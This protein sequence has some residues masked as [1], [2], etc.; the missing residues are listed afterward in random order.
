MTRDWRDYLADVLRYSEIATDLAV[1]SDEANP[2]DVITVL[3]LERA[4][5]IVGEAAGKVP[6][7]VRT[8]YLDLSWQ[9]MIGA[10]NRLAHGYFGL[11]HKLLWRT[12]RDVIPALL[13]RLREVVRLELAE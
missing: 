7:E 13:P 3:A 4:L 6:P 1:G 11:D 5:E 9:A 12:A 10:R 8:R 2:T